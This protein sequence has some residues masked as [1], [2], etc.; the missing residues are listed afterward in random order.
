MKLKH[1]L[2][3]MLLVVSLVP[4]FV[5]SIVMLYQGDRNIE[6]AVTEN[7]KVLCDYQIDAIETF[8][9]QLRADMQVLAQYDFVRDELLISL[10]EREYVDESGR[11]FLDSLLEGRKNFYP[12]ISSLSIV[13]A[14]FRVVAA[15]ET[16]TI[17][18][19]SQLATVNQKLLSQ[20]FFMGDVYIRQIGYTS[21][22]AVLACQK[23]Y[24]G[25]RMIGYIVEEIL[26][27]YFAKYHEDTELWDYGVMQIID[28]KGGIITSG[29]VGEN[30]E[31]FISEQQRHDLKV[32]L[33]RKSKGFESSGAFSYKLDSGRYV[34]CYSEIEY[35]DWLVRVTVNVDNYARQGISFLVLF[36]AVLVIGTL[37]LIAVNYFVTDRMT[38]PIEETCEILKRIQDEEDYSLRIP[39]AREDEMGELQCEINHLLSCV[40][41]SKRN[42]KKEQAEL[43][44]KTE[45]DPM[46]G[47]YNKR[48]IANL[49]EEKSDELARTNGKI[50]VGFVDIDNFKDYN[51]LYGHLEGDHVIKFVANTIRGAVHGA[52]GRYGGDEFVFYMEAQEK[53]L[54]EQTLKILMRRLEQGVINGVTGER[55]SIPCSI[56]VIFENAGTIAGSELVHAADEA[57][58]LAKEKGKNNY[59]IEI[60]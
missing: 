22:R 46:T 37:L 52:V 33:K 18:E 26:V 13:D 42:E 9:E 49:I 57:M 27:D 36:F 21:D 35:S 5:C 8:S 41:D 53:E 2:Y 44:R 51:T 6:N 12:Y 60:R 45:Q 55:M 16:Y 10:G 25:E 15:S 54:I 34:T 7:L 47:V 20:D 29:G 23:V 38:A 39:V 19:Y 14:E 40:S 4:M 48:A 30:S 50:A 58:Y 3:M 1:R 31:D 59:H 17:G 56:G 24:Y 43:T 32:E 28:G 11:E